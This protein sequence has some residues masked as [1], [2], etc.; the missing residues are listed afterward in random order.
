MTPRSNNRR[1]FTLIELLTV[2]AIVLILAALLLP[3][4]T[5]ARSKATRV[6]CVNNL[7]QIG[8]G[9]LVFAHEHGDRFPVK[10][11]TN[12]GGSLEFARTASNLAG[13]F[14]FSFHN[15]KVLSNE[16]STPVLLTCPADARSAA[17]R[18]ALLTDAHVSYFAGGDADPLW[19][20][21]VLAGDGNI[22]NAVPVR[23][24]KSTNRAVLEFGW[25]RQVH[26]GRGNVLFADGR[27]ELLKRLSI[28][29]SPR[30]REG[31]RDQPVSDQRGGQGKPTSGR[32]ANKPDSSPALSSGR[33]ASPGAVSSAT[34][35]GRR[36]VEASDASNPPPVMV[37][38][39]Q[40]ADEWDT[41]NFR[42][43]A[44]LAAAGY[45]ISLLWALVMLLIYFLK[46][47]R[48]QSG[49]HRA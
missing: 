47:R 32:P 35:E 22:T 11:S 43:V 14:L 8:V 34:G 23:D 27:V 16:L 1:G 39:G 26:D 17:A 30:P 48:E 5:T 40:A 38:D 37:V 46:R 24:R 18:F 2:L 10:V 33:T 13:V 21:T 15:F 7:R 49:K 36:V 41:G 31:A 9:S 6:H 29:A 25:T 20:D 42:L 28:S 3:A 45:L 4:L 19:P 44:T 12:Q